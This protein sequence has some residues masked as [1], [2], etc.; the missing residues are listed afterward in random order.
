MERAGC[1]EASLFR[2]VQAPHVISDMR[3]CRR[4][5]RASRQ[6]SCDVAR[7]Q[8]LTGAHQ[9]QAHYKG[10]IRIH[11]FRGR[12]R[13]RLSKPFAWVAP[14]NR[15]CLNSTHIYGTRVQASHDSTSN[16]CTKPAVSKCNKVRAKTRAYSITSSARAI[17][18]GGI[19]RLRALAALRLRT[20]VNLVGC[21]TGRSP[22]LAPL[23]IL[24]T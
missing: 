2:I 11:R 17:S 9:S 12:C 8:W 21:S 5:N 23:R 18:V 22:G 19:S 15:G 10:H 14:P 13:D 20:S 1:D 3:S 6:S 4:Y 7:T 16:S 24:S